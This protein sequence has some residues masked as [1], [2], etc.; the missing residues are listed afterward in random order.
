MGFTGHSVK[1]IE[2]AARDLINERLDL[3]STAGIKLDVYQAIPVA[4]SGRALT[5][6]SLATKTIWG[7]YEGAFRATNG[8]H[9]GL[10]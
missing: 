3:H 7:R 2:D 10:Q 4:H 6:G 8:T 9:E 1:V 5:Y